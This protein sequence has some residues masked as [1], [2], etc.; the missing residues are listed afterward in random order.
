MRG[1]QRACSLD[2]WLAVPAGLVACSLSHQS[3]QGRL[4]PSLS[5][6]LV[7]SLRLSLSGAA[8]AVSAKGGAA[9]AQEAE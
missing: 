5:E 1:S 4:R 6:C 7:V 8:E 2:M 9:S 3:K